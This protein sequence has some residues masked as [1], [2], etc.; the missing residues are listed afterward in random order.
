[1]LQLY[2]IIIMTPVPE[3]LL[4]REKTPCHVVGYKISNCSGVMVNGKW[5]EP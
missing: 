4:Y 5:K 2:R 3:K 1:M